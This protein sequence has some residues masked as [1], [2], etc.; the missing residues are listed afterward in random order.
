MC[1]TA[2]PNVKVK[3]PVTELSGRAVTRLRGPARDN[4]RD[5]ATSW[6]AWNAEGPARQSQPQ[7]PREL[8]DLNSSSICEAGCLRCGQ[9]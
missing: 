6:D 8:P 2:G 5:E 3:A 1:V 9:A 4:S 7:A